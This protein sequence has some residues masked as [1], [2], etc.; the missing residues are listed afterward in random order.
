MHVVC[1]LSKE[2]GNSVTSAL[3]DSLIQNLYNYCHKSNTT[4][5]MVQKLHYLTDHL[6]TCH[7]TITTDDIEVELA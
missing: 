5:G 6:I 1:C 3:S 2:L 4:L 7:T